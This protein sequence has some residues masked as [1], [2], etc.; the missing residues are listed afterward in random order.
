MLSWIAIVRHKEIDVPVVDSASY[1][2]NAHP[3]P[4]AFQQ[5]LNDIPMVDIFHS[6][7]IQKICEE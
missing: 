3:I 1:V 2:L 5:N 6:A 4:S 7:N